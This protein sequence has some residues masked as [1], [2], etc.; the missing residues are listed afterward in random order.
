LTTAIQKLNNKISTLLRLSEKI[1]IRLFLSSSLQEV[2]PYMR[3][4]ELS[5]LPQKLEETVRKVNAKNYDK[6]SF[7]YLDPTTS[8]QA[9]KASENYQLMR[10]EWPDLP[11]EN[12]PGGNGTIGLVMEHGNKVKEIPLIHVMR[13]PLIGKHYELVD[14]QSIQD[15]INENIESLIDINEDLGY[16]ADH[17]TLPLA[18]GSPMNPM[19]GQDLNAV[20]NFR[21]LVTENYSLQP[22][23]LKDEPIPE[24]L[25]CLV[26]AGPTEQFSDYALF[27]MD[28]FLMRG[29][30]LAIFMDAFKEIEPPQQ[31][32]MRFNQPPRYIPANTGL[33]KLLT[34]YGVVVKNSYVLDE[35]CYVQEVPAQ[36]G[37]GQR[38]IYFAPIIKRRF[39]NDDLSFMHNIKGLVAMQ[40]SPLELNSER[41]EKDGLQATKVFSSSEKSWQMKG[42]INLNPMMIRP[43]QS[44]DEQESFAL[45]Y[46]LEGAFTSYFADKSIPEK[47][48]EPD[49]TEA[50]DAPE[51][52]SADAVDLS[53]V[54]A[55]GEVIRQGKP[56]KVF[57]IASSEMLKNNMLDQEGRT[58]NAMFV[59]N[60]IDFLNNREDIAL[61]RS[62]QQRFN[63]L[64]E[65][66]AGTK[67]FVK[68]FNIIGLPV[69]V[70]LFGLLVWFVRHTRRKRI[71][72][73]FQK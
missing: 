6:L 10:L 63:P 67:A 47:P 12:I 3:L 25:D 35:N 61:M 37:G 70:M 13:I 17:G 23:S 51:T 24:S 2:A 60:V 22:I 16:L 58:P 68:W 49:T 42:R 73:M 34:H 55:E 18:G 15:I 28:Q 5:A 56:G 19:G 8:P 11:A 29:K 27:Q 62:K 9:R 66:G 32:G 59:M 41:I 21:S 1:Q 65:T 52:T 64:N 36:F 4:N 38:S 14:L 72:M 45:A 57:V 40:I 44:A 48:S 71:Q 54:A 20:S 46:L 69:I 30:N 26:I 7:D 33:Q 39:I 50:E 43:P 53:M 31:Q